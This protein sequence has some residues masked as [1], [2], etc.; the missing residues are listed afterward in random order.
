MAFILSPRLARALLGCLMAGI[1]FH[2][3]LHFA[4]GAMSPDS[5]SILQ[6]A[7]SGEFSDA[8]PPLMAVIWSWLDKVVPGPAAMLTLQLVLY[9]TGM[10]LILSVF[11]RRHG[12]LVLPIGLVIGLYPPLIGILGA[13]WIDI[14]MAGWLLLAAGLLLHIRSD[15]GTL[16]PYVL[17][18]FLLAITLGVAARHNAAAAAFP[19]VVIAVRETLGRDGEGV[20]GVLLE[21]LIGAIAVACILGL[22]RM[23]S[24]VIVEKPG[25]LWR[26]AALYDIAGVSRLENR[27]LF[28]PGLI[29]VAS[30]DDIRRLYSPRSYIPLVTGEQ[31]HVLGGSAPIHADP[32]TLNTDY[33]DLDR[34]LGNNWR[35]VVLRHPSSYLEHRLNFFRAM[36][37]REPWG[38]FTPIFDMIYPNSLGIEAR[39]TT[40]S[41]PFALS[42]AWSAKSR[43]FEPVVY[44]ALSAALVLPA[45]LVGLRLRDR[46][47]LLVAALYASGLAHMAGLFFFAVTPDFRYSHWL[48]ATTALASGLLLLKVLR[49]LWSAAA[50]FS[51]SAE[52]QRWAGE[53][54]RAGGAQTRAGRTRTSPQREHR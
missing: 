44:L 1:G 10:F 13:I 28:R 31:T 24:A 4:P 40:D 46:S 3:F 20:G 15:S 19:L 22:T 29:K 21:L 38:L 34:E 39:Q 25:D 23:A 37:K 9:Y 14:L 11:A 41:Y 48:I 51:D 26:V 35:E 47:L 6:Q 2:V 43:L 32:L 45:F 16:R 7:R 8:H 42:R 49:A 5:I 54:D 53:A 30:M 52:S 18:F 50:R 33:P 17:A 12:L 27:N 36:V